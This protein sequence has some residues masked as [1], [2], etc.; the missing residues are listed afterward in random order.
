MKLIELLDHDSGLC[1]WVYGVKHANNLTET[2]G[3]GYCAVVHGKPTPRSELPLE[4]RK[5]VESYMTE[6]WPE[7]AKI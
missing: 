6:N 3:Q 2:M 5:L 1:V 4:L 7:H